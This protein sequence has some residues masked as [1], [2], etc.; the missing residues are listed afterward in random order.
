[1]DPIE[2]RLSELGF[3]LPESPTPRA[4]YV[5]F[6]LIG[7]LL[8]ISGQI[9]TAGGQDKFVGKVGRD[10]TVEDGQKAAQLCALNMLSQ[11]RTALGGRF[12]R[13]V[14]CVRLG[15][16]VN[17]HPDFGQQPQVINGASDLIVHALG[18]AGRH[19][20]FAVG[21]IS[22]PRNVAVEIDGMF[23]VNP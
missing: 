15:G 7:N 1:M 13:L 18:D 19:T 17:C 5:P 6:R 9:P 20:R 16:F 23:E 8:F 10:L 11:V 2:H 12:D 14:S 3:A 4:N 21:A 22:L